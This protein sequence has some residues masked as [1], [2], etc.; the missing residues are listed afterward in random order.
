MKTAMQI[1]AIVP[2]Y[3]YARF[4]HRAVDSVLNQTYPVAE[5][6]VVDDGSTDNTREV[7]AA[8]GDRIK[9]VHQENRG[10]S[11]ARNTGIRNASSPWVAFLDSDDWWLPEK[12][13]RQ[14][15]LVEAD[16]AVELVYTASWLHFPDGQVERYDVCT[17]DRLWPRFRYANGITPST[18]LMRR[19]L[20]L[21]AGCFDET[22]RYC[23]D[24]DMWVRLGPHIHYAAVLDPVIGYQLT[25]GSLSSNVEKELAT[26]KRVIEKTVLKGMQGWQ[27]EYWRRLAMSAVLF[28][29]SVACR[30][31]GP[32]ASRR[33]L[34]QSLQCWPSPFFLPVRWTALAW[35]G[36]RSLGLSRQAS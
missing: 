32:E 18:V 8:Y 1:S 22:L 29:S 21:K 20:I 25:P 16:P 6:I 3:N 2:T 23:E 31:S 17:P 34:R 28:R 15:R 7:L 30:T 11:G 19:D 36:R 12:I 14:V 24:W 4:V 5:V 13:E 33:Y 27:R 9:Y 10:L 35:E 26:A